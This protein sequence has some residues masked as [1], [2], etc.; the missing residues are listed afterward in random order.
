MYI[1]VIR[2]FFTAVSIGRKLGIDF[3]LSL[4]LSLNRGEMVKS[5]RLLV[6]LIQA[7]YT[8]ILSPSIARPI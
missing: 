5:L 7:L 8:P 2:N 6:F 1:Y 3:K 4:L